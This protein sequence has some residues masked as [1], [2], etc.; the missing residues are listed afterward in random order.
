MKLNLKKRFSN[1]T[2][3]VAFIG[4]VVLLVQ[5]VGLGQYLPDNLMDIVN[6]ILT[7]LVMLGI[8]VDPTTEGISDSQAVLENK[9][10]DELRKEI[11]E[12]K[13]KLGE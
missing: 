2:F 1:K 4:A 8:V 5:Q 13:E 7:L 12:L 9:T 11:E 3:C 6:S 10:S